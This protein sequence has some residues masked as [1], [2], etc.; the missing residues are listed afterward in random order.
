L[1]LSIK[2]LL[3]EYFSKE[4]VQDA[5][6]DIG[7]TTSGTKEELVDILTASW[8]SHNRDNYELLYFL[9]KTGLQKICY[10]YNLDA[11]STNLDSYIKRIKK[12]NLFGSIS[13]SVP[14]KN[15]EPQKETR[16]F[17]RNEAGQLKVSKKGAIL[18][19]ISIG[20][21]IISIIVTIA[22]SAK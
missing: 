20:V 16:M 21:T 19:I 10:H 17:S 4:Q 18:T 1:G 7:E 13:D 12:A 9:D 11:T 22:Y 2:R 8:K 14:K 3:L 5:L 6:R 15:A